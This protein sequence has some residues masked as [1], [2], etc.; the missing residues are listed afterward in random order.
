MEDGF[1]QN[2]RSLE[3][4]VGAYLEFYHETNLSEETLKYNFWSGMDDTLG[5]MLL[6]DA[7]HLSFVQFLDRAL[8]VCGSSLSVGLAEEISCGF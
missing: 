6:L 4:Y 7:E 8:W 2:G 1:Y 3:E 5:A